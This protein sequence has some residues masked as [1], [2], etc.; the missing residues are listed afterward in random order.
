L[1]IPENLKKVNGQEGGSGGVN[2]KTSGFSN[3]A[4]VAND[5]LFVVR[6]PGEM[7]EGKRRGGG[8]DKLKKRFGLFG[9]RFAAEN[10][11]KR[12]VGPSTSEYEKD[13][14]GLSLRGKDDLPREYVGGR[15]RGFWNGENG[16]LPCF[17][18]GKKTENR[19]GTGT[20][21]NNPQGR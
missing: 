17:H 3:S 7:E 4:R 5:V 14:G 20:K 21:S 16:G 1:R 8:E 11:N 9:R 15:V 10:C 19:S 18:G 12:L 6:E 13:D 2:S